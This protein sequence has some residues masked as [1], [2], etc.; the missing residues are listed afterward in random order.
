MLKSKREYIEDCGRKEDHL[1]ARKL[2]T[3][4]EL[5]EYRPSSRS[6]PLFQWVFWWAQLVGYCRRMENNELGFHQEE[7]DTLALQALNGSP[8]AVPLKAAT[9]SAPALSVDVHPKSFEVLLEFFH[10]RDWLLQHLADRIEAIRLAGDVADME[11]LERASAELSYQTRLL[12]YGACHPGVG[13]PFRIEE[14]T[15]AIPEPFTSLLPTDLLRINEAFMYVNAGQLKALDR[16]VA[17]PKRKGDTERP[18][19]SIFIGQLAMKLKR[20]VERL[21]RDH[22]LVQ[23][24][25]TVKLA[26]PQTSALDEDALEEAEV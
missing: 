3:E 14:D 18:S 10:A 2:A 25:A 24:L 5:D 17:P 11:L 6:A 16:L 1:R 23:L 8:I 9:E 13:L 22:A 26:T 21:M 12:A 19:H 20:P 7:A 15:P 4:A